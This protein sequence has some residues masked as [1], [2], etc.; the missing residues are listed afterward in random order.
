MKT[1]FLLRHAKSS[2]ADPGA[3][4]FD[5]PLNARGEQAAEAIGRELRR[6]GL[7]FDAIV[8]S[9]AA[10]AI[11]TL[12]RAG[13]GYGAPFAA[14]EDSRVYLASPATLLAIVH[15]ADD[16]VDRLLLVGHNPGF[17]QFAAGLTE[18]GEGPLDAVTGG[19]FPTGAFAEIALP[20][21]HWREAEL[22][23]GRLIRF[24]RP[25]ELKD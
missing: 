20:I 4:D 3:H 12:E 7:V 10:R 18:C 15:E 23:T 9:P 13:R 17:E 5:R 25:K 16:A 8:T 11:E 19:K 22:G 21:D 14:R 6:L 1:L 2:W 24:V